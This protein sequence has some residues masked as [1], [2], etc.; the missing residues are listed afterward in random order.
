LG[1]NERL[2][3]IG[4]DLI[5]EFIISPSLSPFIQG[6][7]GFGGMDLDSYYYSDDSVGEVNLKVGLGL[8]VRVTPVLELL[9]GLDFQWR[10]WG[11]VTEYDPG[12]GYYTLETE[13]DSRRFYIGANFH[14]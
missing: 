3:E 8:M 13:D 7:V 12:Y 4:L 9:G 6:G 2:G 5:K 14:F 1:S 11:D 10:Q